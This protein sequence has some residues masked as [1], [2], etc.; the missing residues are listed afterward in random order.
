MTVE[1]LPRAYSYVRFS[2]PDQ[3]KGDSLRRQTSA[4]EEYAERHGLILDTDL[5]F[6]DLGVSGFR[7][8]N[9]EDGRLADF[10]AAVQTGTV[11]RGS[12]LLVENLDRISRQSARK[13]FRVLESSLKPASP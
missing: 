1:G 6:R 12:Y 7:G 13:A 4:A 9:A 3:M 10:L 11:H 2:T 5:T 8:R